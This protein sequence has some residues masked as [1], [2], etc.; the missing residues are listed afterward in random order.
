MQ[1]NSEGQIHLAARLYYVDGLGQAEVAKL[2]KVSQAK[3]SRLLSLAREKGIVRISVA[4]YQSRSTVLEKQL[5]KRFQLR[6]VIVIRTVEGLSSAESRHMVAHF[7]APIIAQTVLPGSA[8]AIGGGHA[9]EELV[10][11]LPRENKNVTVVQAMGGVDP[12]IAPF[13]SLTLGQLLADKWAG[14]FYMF[15]APAVLPDKRT[16]DTFLDLEHI[17]SVNAKLKEVDVALI[18]VGTLEQSVFVER[19]IFGKEGFDRFRKCGAIGEICGRYFDAEGKECDTPYRDR[20]IGISLETLREI[21]DV[22]GVVAGADRAAAVKAA[23][24]SCVLKS[25]II[26]EIGAQALL[27]I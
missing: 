27:K 21:P 2:V 6:N 8:L 1:I 9:L 23:I 14:R 15:N 4:D 25:L 19:N 24:T 11:F 10:Q 13:D 3:V 26:D 5:S 20:I 17:R 22:I 18:G 12:N 16:R 7:A